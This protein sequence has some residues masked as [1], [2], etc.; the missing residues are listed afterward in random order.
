MGVRFT[1]SDQEESDHINENWDDNFEENIVQED[2]LKVRMTFSP[3]EEF[4]K[5]YKNYARVRVLEL[6]KSFQKMEMMGKKNAL[7]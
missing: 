7:F 5:Y 6:V 1:S 2:E 4:T 3:E